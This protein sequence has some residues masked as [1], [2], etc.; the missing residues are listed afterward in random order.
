G[1]HVHFIDLRDHYFKYPFHMLTFSQATWQ[2]WLNPTSNLNR[3]RLADYRRVFEKTFGVVQFDILE[4]DAQH[5]AALR[6]RIKPEF[7][8]G[9]DEMDAVTQI[10]VCARRPYVSPARL[11]VEP[12]SLSAEI[13]LD[14]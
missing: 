14:L 8:S 10:R 13:G 4:R 1:L 2:S 3:Y 7:L 5:F 9:D 11:P 6:D 12:G